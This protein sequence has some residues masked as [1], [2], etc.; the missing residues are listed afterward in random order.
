M[1][2]DILDVKEPVEEDSVSDTEFLETDT[3][4]GNDG[5]ES[6]SNSI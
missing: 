1:D 6:V 4:Y 3:L 5:V 2:E